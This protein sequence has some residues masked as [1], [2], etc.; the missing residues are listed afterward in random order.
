M[1]I[2]ELKY[3]LQSY[4]I[5]KTNWYI[6]W[7]EFQSSF[8]FPP[9][10]HNYVLDSLLRMSSINP[11]TILSMGF[12]GQTMGH[13]ANFI[14]GYMLGIHAHRKSL[15]IPNLPLI[16]L[17][18][19]FYR[20]AKWILLLAPSLSSVGSIIILLCGYVRVNHY[21]AFKNMSIGV[22]MYLV[23]HKI[24]PNIDHIDWAA[25]L[26]NINI[27]SSVL[28]IWNQFSHLLK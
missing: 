4:L 26:G 20:Y 21:F 24:V 16:R 17:K 15:I 25:I 7:D 1:I 14:T 10:H 23:L 3:L 12:C 28:N 13:I 2:E 19:Y 27:S 18:F 9:I 6:L 8:I 11:L 5:N 22:F